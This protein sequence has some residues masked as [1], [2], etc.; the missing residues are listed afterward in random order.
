MTTAPEGDFLREDSTVTAE[1]VVITDR[2]IKI[3]ALLHQSQRNKSVRKQRR[4]DYTIVRYIAA[5]FLGI[6]V[7]SMTERARLE[8]DE[9]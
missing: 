1:V 6:C 4:N 8:Q 5:Q 3:K 9:E 2:F 7:C